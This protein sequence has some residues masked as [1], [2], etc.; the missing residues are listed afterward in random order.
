MFCWLQIWQ[1]PDDQTQRWGQG[2][3]LCCKIGY[4]SLRG[5]VLQI[6]NNS[7]ATVRDAIIFLTDDL[8]HNHKAVQYFQ[9]NLQYLKSECQLPIVKAR[10]FSD[11]GSSQLKYNGTLAAIAIYSDI[12]WKY[13]GSDHRKADADGKLGSIN[14]ALDATITGRQA[15]ISD[16]R[17]MTEW[18]NQDGHLLID[19]PGS[20][21]NFHH[22]V[23]IERTSPKS[24]A[25]SEIYIISKTLTRPTRSSCVCPG[26]LFG[27]IL[28]IPA[29]GVY[30]LY[31][32]TTLPQM[33]NTAWKCHN[34]H[35]T[36]V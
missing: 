17:G 13:F 22:V 35:Y 32:R 10:V 20:K 31:P 19:A 7:Q 6:P 33:H 16:T 21:W 15:I 11:G 25:W 24:L 18:C 2:R 5:D 12:S 30:I 27:N 26:C 23:S 34:K 1:E 29:R 8:L 3:I 36:R 4:H 14:R 28:A 9:K